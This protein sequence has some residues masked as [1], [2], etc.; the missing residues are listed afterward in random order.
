MNWR[1]RP[2][3]SHEVV[4]SLI[5]ATTNKRGLKV[6]AHLDTGSYPKGLKITNAEVAAQKVSDDLSAKADQA[7]IQEPLP[8]FLLPRRLAVG[9]SRRRRGRGL[10]S[11][12]QR[13]GPRAERR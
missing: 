1:G 4:V 12:P 9:R 8:D 6:K 10:G 7:T 5:G 3:T 13:L 11:R 2:L